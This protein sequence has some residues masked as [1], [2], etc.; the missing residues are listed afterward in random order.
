[1][2]AFFPDEWA[3]LSLV[4]N[5]RGVHF[6]RFTSPAG[7]P[8]SATL[9]LTNPLDP[10]VNPGLTQSESQIPTANRGASDEYSIFVPPSLFAL[11]LLGPP[12]FP[13][14]V[15]LLYCVGAEYNR[16]GLRTFFVAATDRVLVT[17]P[18]V[19]PQASTGN[20]AWGIGI[21]PG[22]INL[23]FEAAGA[24]NITNWQVDTVAGYSTGY[25]GV[26][27]TVNNA[28]VGLSGI[29]RV[30]FY[31]ALYW[32][33]EPPAPSGSPNPSTP[34]GVSPPAAGSP[35][36]T[37]RMLNALSAAN[38][39]VERIAYEVTDGGTPRDAGKLR[40]AVP[41]A[42]LINLK[43]QTKALT[44]LALARI[45]GSGVSD[46]YFPTSSLPAAVN[47]LIAS[48]P[49]RGTLASSALT[50]GRASAGTLADWGTA[51]ATAVNGAVAWANTG[52]G[53]I[54]THALMGWAVPDV[55]ALCH[56]AFLQEFA[57]EFLAG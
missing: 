34:P 23:L 24:G 53:L 51:H 49:A 54:R 17:I 40:A 4:P 37:W 20:K 43:P 45:L 18:G 5:P 8:L 21:T 28:L 10:S 11:A 42:G 31:D 9:S 6:S 2:D 15:S 12:P 16:H 33:D 48:L 44:A 3:P 14:K 30:L 38:P 1:L 26:N 55:G 52:V 32:G 35:R 36:D 50:A 19:E 47:T 13:V 22:M 39:S 7:T 56:D 29:R 41:T 27:G 46:G 25:R 57:W